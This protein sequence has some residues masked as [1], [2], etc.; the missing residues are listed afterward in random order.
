MESYPIRLKAS[1]P[2]LICFRLIFNAARPNCST[3]PAV[4]GGFL[5]LISRATNSNS[6]ETSSFTPSRNG[7]TGA[8][9]LG[10]GFANGGGIS[11]L[12]FFSL[13]VL[14]D[15]WVGEVLDRERLLCDPFHVALLT[16]CEGMSGTLTVRVLVSGAFD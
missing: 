11:Y 2:P 1:S 16:T 10:T 7:V 3:S 5:S 15:L 13:S 9:K 6:S 14:P 8:E 4:K 12:R